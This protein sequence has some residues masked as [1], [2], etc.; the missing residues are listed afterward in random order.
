MLVVKHE[1]KTPLGKPKRKREDIRR[2]L[3]KTK[4]GAADWIYL[5]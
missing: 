5:A 1:E 4:W 3:G 2:D